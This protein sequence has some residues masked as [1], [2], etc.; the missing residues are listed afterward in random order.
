V[1]KVV[2]DNSHKLWV[3]TSKG[4]MN[5]DPANQQMVVYTK[6]NGLLSDYFNYNSGF[7]DA[8][9]T[10]YFGSI[11]GM[12][13]FKPGELINHTFKPAVYITGLQV[14][15]R[16]LSATRDSALLKRSIV[17]ANRIELPYD[18]SSI[19]MD[20]AALSYISPDRTA[21]SYRMEGVEKNWTTIQPNR[22]V[23]YTNLSPGEYI[24]KVKAVVNGAAGAAERQLVIRILPPFWASPLAYL[25]YALLVLAIGF[26]LIRSYHRR[27]QK[28]KEKEDFEARI[29]FFTHVAHEIRTPLTLIKGPLEHLLE[30]TNEQPG[31]KDDLLMMERNTNRLMALINHILDFRQVEVKRYSLDF[32]RINIRALLQESCEDF[33]AQAKKRALVYTIDLPASS[34]NIIAD[35]EALQRIFSNLLSNAI[36]YADKQVTVKLY[37]V[38]RDDTYFMIE[39]SNDGHIISPEMREKIFQ[40]FFRLKE[41]AKQKGTGIGL[42]L[43]RSLAE[44]HN[45]KLYLKNNREPVNIFV[46]QIPLKAE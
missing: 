28:K 16:E 7:K 35:E 33:A 20:F 17:Y 9:G 11:K 10:L 24:F 43:A 39:I 13:S 19:S 32:T 29:D 23:Y 6:S 3:S 25:L 34:V 1:F 42:T 5:F 31:I 26:Y 40:P 14:H 45:G 44:L 4:L 27:T 18:Q 38:A 37:P 41:T 36:K 15:N 8:A 12:I 46:L 21:Y 2:E 30:K 22:K